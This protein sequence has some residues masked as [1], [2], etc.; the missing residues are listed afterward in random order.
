MAA[1]VLLAVHFGQ[2]LRLQPLANL[3]VGHHRCPGP[4]GDGI[5]HMIAM[6]VRDQDEIG[7]H[8]VGLGRR[9]GI[10]RQERINEHAPAIAFQQQTRM[11]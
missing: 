11:P 6:A 8:L 10:A 2:S 1:A 9:R 5:T 7:S 4:L 3:V